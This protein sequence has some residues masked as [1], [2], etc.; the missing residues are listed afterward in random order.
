M[1]RTNQPTYFGEGHWGRSETSGLLHEQFKH[2]AQVFEKFVGWSKEHGVD[3]NGYGRAVF[4]H[5]HTGEKSS[6]SIAQ[7]RASLQNG[8]LTPHDQKLLQEAHDHINSPA[9]VSQPRAEGKAEDKPAVLY[10]VE[11]PQ[12]AEPQPL[13]A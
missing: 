7:I 8:D 2:V 13:S 4:E 6:A 5:V 10:A 9:T 1:R 11:T 12:Q 3:L